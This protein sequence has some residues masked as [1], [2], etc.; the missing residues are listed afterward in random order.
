MFSSFLAQRGWGDEAQ[1]LE[2]RYPRAAS[3]ESASHAP[4]VAVLDQIATCSYHS[5]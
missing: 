5:L 3:R 2:R 1:S 4:I